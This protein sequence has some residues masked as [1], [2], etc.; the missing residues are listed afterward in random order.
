MIEKAGLGIAVQNA[1]LKLKEKAVVCEYTNEENA[2][3]KII[4]KYGYTEDCK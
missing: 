3:A 1:D 2:I 4:E